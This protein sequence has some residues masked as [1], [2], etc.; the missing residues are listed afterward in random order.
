MSK[1]RINAHCHL[2][3]HQFI[4]DEMT[5]KLAFGIPEHLLKSGAIKAASRLGRKAPREMLIDYDSTID[6]VTTN[7][8]ERLTNAG[9]DIC[10]PLMLD[11]E[12]WYKQILGLITDTHRGEIN[13]QIF[14]DLAAHQCLSH[15]KDFKNQYFQE[16]K[17]PMDIKD[18]DGKY[19][20]RDRILFGTDA[21]I[22]SVS[23]TE[24]DYEKPYV[25]PQNLPVELQEMIF[26]NN[27][28]SF[29]FNEEGKIP[30][31][32]IKNNGDG[33]FYEIIYS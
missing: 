27:P 14:T 6:I 20:F 28:I 11:L 25:D 31:S 18:P 21:S 29:L 7:Y 12:Y 16:L 17:K 8:I 26:T 4:P 9:I 22:T 3:I 32:W 5:Q 1:P 13:G 30:E 10:V 33:N 19:I 15:D 23:G 2:L 24:I